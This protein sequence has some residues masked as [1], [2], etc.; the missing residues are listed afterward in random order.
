M[1]FY[2]TMEGGELDLPHTCHHLC[3]EQP[4]SEMLA[5]GPEELALS[6]KHRSML[7]PPV[8]QHMEADSPAPLLPVL[9]AWL[10]QGPRRLSSGCKGESSTGGP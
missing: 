9:G 10:L 6:H 7:S 8:T 3:Q 1:S 5:L 2:W 4:V